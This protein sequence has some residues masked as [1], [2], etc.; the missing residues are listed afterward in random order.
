MPSDRRLHPASIVFRLIGQ[1]REFGVPIVL[2]LV[3]GSRGGN[4]EAW[5]LVMLVPYTLLA[6]VRYVSFTY[7]F[8]PHELVVR[9]GLVFRNERHVPYERIQNLD[10]VRNV[11]HRA[12]GVVDVHV[13]TGSGAATDARLSVVTWA[14]YEEM[15]RHVAAGRD[16]AP[17]LLS[18]ETTADEPDVLLEL[19]LRELV[20]HG[21]IDNRGGIVIV[22]AVGALFEMGVVDRLVERFVDAEGAAAGLVSDIVTSFAARVVPWNTLGT[23]LLL[24]AA[25]LVLIRVFSVVLAIVR[26]HGFRLMQKNEDLR[27]EYGLLTRVSAAIPLRRIQTVTIADGL[28]ARWAGRVAIRADTAGAGDERRG[29]RRESLA[30]ILRRERAPV[31]LRRVLPELDLAAVSWQPA[32]PGAV[33]RQV[34][35]RLL[36]AGAGAS[37][38]TWVLGWWTVPFGAVLAAWAAVSARQHVAHLG[39]ATIDGAVLFRSGWIT[40]HLTIARFTRIQNV[41]LSQS[42]FDRRHG[43]ASVRVDTAG[44]GA[45]SH[46]VHIPYLTLEAAMRL[47]ADLFAAAARTTFRW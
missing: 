17:T 44:A 8:E 5:A 15:R 3:A 9:S 23:A 27:A 31:L 29:R 13:D 11:L 19:P 41:Q 4:L 37:L 28:L 38:V 18:G 6:V 10:A 47:R 22:G 20:V 45:S 14:A 35:L 25:G 24:L 12:L 32:A 34:R 42:P 26:L 39:W 46:R 33:G 40:R 21:L 16:L 36:V 2:G 30:P 43:M 1:V 7:R